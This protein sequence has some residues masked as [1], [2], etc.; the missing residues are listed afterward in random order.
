M[1]FLPL[2]Y[3]NES[4]KYV[5]YKNAPTISLSSEIESKMDNLYNEIDKCND[6]IIDDSSR[7]NAKNSRR[8]YKIKPNIKSKW[9]TAYAEI[10]RDIV[11]QMKD[12]PRDS[13]NKPMV[14]LEFIMACSYSLMS[15]FNLSQA[16]IAGIFGMQPSGYDKADLYPDLVCRAFKSVDG[17]SLCLIPSDK[18]SRGIQIARYINENIQTAHACSYFLGITNDL[19]LFANVVSNDKKEF[20]LTRPTEIDNHF[21]VTYADARYRFACGNWIWRDGK[22]IAAGVIKNRIIEML[23]LKKLES[24][25]RIEIFR[26]LFKSET[27]LSQYMYEYSYVSFQELRS[28][29]KKSFEII[30]RAKELEI[31]GIPDDIEYTDPLFGAISPDD[32]ED[33]LERAEEKEVQKVLSSEEIVQMYVS[34]AE[35]R[36]DDVEDQ[37]LDA[38]NIK[39]LVKN[40]TPIVECMVYSLFKKIFRMDDNKDED[41]YENQIDKA[42]AF[43]ILEAFSDGDF[44]FEH[45]NN[46][47]QYLEKKSLLGFIDKLN[48]PPNIRHGKQLESQKMHIHLEDDNVHLEELLEKYIFNLLKNKNPLRPML[49]YIDM[50]DYKGDIATELSS[51]CDYN[52]LPV[53]HSDEDLDGVCKLKIFDANLNLYSW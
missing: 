53:I 39:K 13:R 46:I 11:Q 42:A 7:T 43:W 8:L 52:V 9:T 40:K 48:A 32:F 34:E 21:S 10:H 33:A 26:D 44:S 12:E 15:R 27:D 30:E 3:N 17:E 38:L 49:L 4:F 50:D 29:Y 5:I 1:E 45:F 23:D 2:L 22:Y 6:E 51:I 28:I 14:E 41:E 20:V 24:N 18:M 16:E 35:K 25:E 19:D 31:T 36:I 37:L 47:C